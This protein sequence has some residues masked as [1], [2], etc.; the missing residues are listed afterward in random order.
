VRLVNAATIVLWTLA[1]VPL[2]AA[3]GAVS[4]MLLGGKDLGNSLAAALGAL[5]GPVAAVPAVLVTL[6]ALTFA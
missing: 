4:G 6:I 1:A 3:A 5:Y 2:S